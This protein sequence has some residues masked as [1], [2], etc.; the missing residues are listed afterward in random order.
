MKLVC[1]KLLKDKRGKISSALINQAILGIII[2]VILFQAY[3]ALVPEAQ[4]AGDMMN[5]SNRCIDVG[6]FYN[7]TSSTCFGLANESILCPT[8]ANT[9]PLGG[10]FSGSGV[11]FI[12]I[13]AA[14][15]I[16]VIRSFLKKGK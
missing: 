5:D 16:V 6:C 2:I 12:I 9:I 4:S 8:N 14:L 7:G 10:I 1:M 3:A 15:V 11:V 13:M